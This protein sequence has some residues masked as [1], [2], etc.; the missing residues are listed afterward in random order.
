MLVDYERVL[1]DLRGIIASKKSHG[2]NDLLVAMAELE[3]D[4]R[5]PEGLPER[6]LRQYGNEISSGIHA[7]PR[8]TEAAP[9]SERPDGPD[10][11][12]ST[13]ASAQRP[14]EDT[15]QPTPAPAMT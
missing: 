7:A 5:I 6:A 2:R 14:K 12:E 13:T 3:A 15:W 9:E 11:A 8:P 1:I 4:Y 10:I